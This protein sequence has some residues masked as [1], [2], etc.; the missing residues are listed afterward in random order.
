MA[1]EMLLSRKYGNKVDVYSF[2]I[3]VWQM[4]TAK[5]LSAGYGINFEAHS[6]LQVAFKVAMENHRPII[7]ANCSKSLSHLITKW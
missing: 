7:P 1:P 3:I 4:L 2:A 5:K 6:P